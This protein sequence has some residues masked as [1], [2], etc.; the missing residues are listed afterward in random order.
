MGN[1]VAGQKISQVNVW[2][3]RYSKNSHARTTICTNLQTKIV[4]FDYINKNSFHLN[5]SDRFLLTLILISLLV[6]VISKCILCTAHDNELL[7][8]CCNQ[9]VP[10]HDMRIALFKTVII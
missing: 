1:A 3:R 4:D 10:Y 7:V 8:P 5:I 9:K 6:F 2:S